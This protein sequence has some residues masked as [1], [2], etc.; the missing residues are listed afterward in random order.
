M[1]LIIHNH[2]MNEK[3]SLEINAKGLWNFICDIEW[4]CWSYLGLFIVLMVLCL[5]RDSKSKKL[6]ADDRG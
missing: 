3:M 5:L 2:K 1:P 6:R 4:W